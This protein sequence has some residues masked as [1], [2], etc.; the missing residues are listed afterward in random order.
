MSESGTFFNGFAD[1]FDTF[2]D[3]KRGPFMRWVDQTYRCDMFVRFEKTFQALGNLQGKRVL[4]VGCGS[5][6]YLAEALKRGAAHVTGIDPARRMLELARQRVTQCNLADRA[7]L[8]EGYF[9]L[10]APSTRFDLSI[11]MG[12][13]DYVDD[14]AGFLGSLH[15]LISEKAVLSFPSTHWFRTPLRKVRYTARRCPVYFYT[16]SKIEHVIK[17]AGFGSYEIDKIPGAG[18]D[19]VVCLRK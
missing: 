19:F 7:T 10:T 11:V 15:T 2:Y 17:E 1:S 16:P 6:P 18:M 9:P 14:P 13:M 5:G 8:I 3:Q 4:D 12:V